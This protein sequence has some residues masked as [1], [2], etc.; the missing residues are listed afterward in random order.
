MA[1]EDDA[2]H[3]PGLPLV[4]VVGRVGADDRGDPRV[5]VRA[6]HLDA[7]PA[8]PVG[9]RLEVVDRV[10]LGALLLRPVHPGHAGAD[11]EA[12]PR[13]VAQRAHDRRQ[14]VT[15][16]VQGE[17]VTVHDHALETGGDGLRGRGLQGVDHLVE[18]GAVGAL[19]GPGQQ[20]GHLQP[21]V[22][23]GVGAQR[24]AEHPLLVRDLHRRGGVGLHRRGHGAATALLGAGRV[25]LLVLGALRGVGAVLGG[26][27]GRRLLV[28]H[29]GSATHHARLLPA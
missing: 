17:L 10:Q 9:D 29:L 24:A 28:R 23:G 12:Q 21:A 13:V 27:L 8:H 1:V 18:V 26:L 11:L 25:D 5:V 19:R 14:V 20:H 6:G 16:H 22:A 15:V 4:P 2:E 3:V 7:H